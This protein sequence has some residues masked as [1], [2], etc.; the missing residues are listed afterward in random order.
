VFFAMHAVTAALAAGL[1]LV[2]AWASRRREG[3]ARGMTTIALVA[4]S[5]TVVMGVAALL[6]ISRAWP[7]PFTHAVVGLFPAVMGVLPFLSIAY[8]AL[9][10]YQLRGWKPGPAVAG[11]SILAIAAVF[12]AIGAHSHSPGLLVRLAHF[13]PA[14]FAVSG[15]A[16]MVRFAGQDEAR[17]GARMAF[18]ATLLQSATGVAYAL[19]VPSL[20]KGMILLAPIASAA[21]LALMLGLLAFGARITRFSAIAAAAGMFFV[22]LSMASLREG[23]RSGRPRASAEGVRRESNTHFAF[24]HGIQ[25]EGRLRVSATLRPIRGPATPSQSGSCPLWTTSRSSS[26][27]PT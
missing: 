22:V 15:V 21:G 11:G 12:A 17:F 23:I 5:V 19:S 13:V 27:T 24:E 16:I 26:F 20:P 14:A 2:I 4:L 10:A 25:E 9:Y 3:L 8:A 7:R 18:V 6:F 1:P